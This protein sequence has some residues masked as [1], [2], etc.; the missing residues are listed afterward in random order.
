MAAIE[1]KIKEL[2]DS[3]DCVLCMELLYK[4]YTLVCGH[5]FCSTCIS[6]ETESKC[7]SCRAVYIKPIDYNRSMDKTA[8]ILFPEDYSKKVNEPHEDAEK[9]KLYSTMYREIAERA[10]KDYASSPPPAFD[11]LVEAA[12]SLRK[13]PKVLY[14]PFNI[15]NKIVMGSS[16]FMALMIAIEATDVAV[17]V[18]LCLL[19][20]SYLSN[21]MSRTAINWIEYGEGLFRNDSAEQR[22]AGRS[23]DVVNSALNTLINAGAITAMPQRMPPPIPIPRPPQMMADYMNMPIFDLPRRRP[24]PFDSSGGL[25]RS[26]EPEMNDILPD[27]VD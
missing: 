2:R 23:N 4:P 9:D 20:V 10:R 24:E 11:R 5:S 14:Y 12:A 25:M 17:G 21:K 3:F 8:M 7:P 1:E 15:Y 22:S 19:F 18:A 6:K 27:P 16:I 13:D 26:I